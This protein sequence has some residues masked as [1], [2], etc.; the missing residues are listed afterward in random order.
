[1]KSVFAALLIVLLINLLAVAGFAGWLAMSDRL[2]QERVDAIV[3][4]F[5]P[6]IAQDRQAEAE[7][8][9]MAKEL[10]EEQTRLARLAEVAAGPRSLDQRL[11]ANR[12]TDD[13]TREL[14]NRLTT[15]NDSIRERL[16][17][18]RR[19]IE[20]RL[21]K[22]EEQRESFERLVEERTGRL[23]EEDFRRAVEAFEQLKAPQGKAALEAMLNSGQREEAIEYLSA[24]DGRKSAAILR[25]YKQPAEA[26]RVAELI[27]ALRQRTSVLAEAPDSDA[28]AG[29]PAGPIEDPET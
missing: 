20:I 23:Q 29:Q 4:M 13:Y 18:D 24:M 6:T 3:A 15:E 2:N 11:L 8:E 21:A 12:A 19:L 10:A 7:A 27:E 22:L 9:T 14:L 26:T 17:Q 28:N 25:E 1:M 5:K 16:A